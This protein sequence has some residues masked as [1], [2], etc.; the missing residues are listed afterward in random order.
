MCDHPAPP[1]DRFLTRLEPLFSVSTGE[2]REI[3]VHFHREMEA[4]LA[5]RESSLRMLPT[6]VRRPGGAEKGRFLVVDLGG[7]NLR[8]LAVELDGRGGARTLAV[9]RCAIPRERMGGRGRDLFDFM[10][11]CVEA[12]FAERDLGQQRTYD[13][14]F[15]FSFPVEQRSPASGRLIAWTK[16]FTA[17]GV[18]GRDVVAL[19]SEALA[20]RGL[21]FVRIAALANDTVGTFAAG[22]Y[23]DPS[24]DMGVILGTGTNAC[25]PEKVA[26]IGKCPAP[27]DPGE[28]VVNMEWGGFRRLKRNAYDEALDLAS[29]NPGRQHLEKLVSGM[30]LGEIARKVIAEMVGQGLLFDPAA[31][32]A[33]SEA[34]GFSTERLSRIARGEESFADFGLGAV[35]PEDRRTVREI[36]RLIA[37][38]SARIAGAAMAAVVTWMDPALASPHTIAVDGTLFEKYPGYREEILALFGDLF[39]ERAGGITLDLVKDGSGVGAAVI[40]AVEAAACPRA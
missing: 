12:F 14:A 6:F 3:I 27:G 21:G 30:Y 16:G 5:G 26:R 4:G 23:A 18:V 11:G 22:A 40:A 20:R 25:Y 24:C 31:L 29:P 38:R 32:P 33:F 17:S 36:G 28:M 34:Y 7:T 37:A 13:L 19:F 10:A 9:S 39:G 2:A 35:S 1:G 15:T 8:V